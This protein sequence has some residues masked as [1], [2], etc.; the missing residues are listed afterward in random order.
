MSDLVT[1]TAPSTAAPL[2]GVDEDPLESL[3]RRLLERE[4]VDA[5]PSDLTGGDGVVVTVDGV[6][7]EVVLR[8]REEAKP[9]SLSPREQEIV[10]LVAKGLPNKAIAGILDLSL[11]TVGTH[12]RRAFA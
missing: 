7:Y 11:W 2:A 1:D 10:R 4:T 12:L 5:E 3:I 9:P 6:A 8:L